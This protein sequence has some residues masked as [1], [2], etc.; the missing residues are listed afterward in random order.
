MKPE[1]SV[2]NAWRIADLLLGVVIASRYANIV[3]PCHSADGRWI[4]N[5]FPG[6][7]AG[8]ACIEVGHND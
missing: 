3:S 4:A 2:T 6:F 8:I 7:F 5:V 1:N